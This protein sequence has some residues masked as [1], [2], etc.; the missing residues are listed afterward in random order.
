MPKKEVLQSRL[1]APIIVLLMCIQAGVYW[2]DLMGYYS[3][4][5]SLV[6]MGLAE[7]IV[8]PW[9]YGEFRMGGGG[10]RGERDATSGWE[11]RETSR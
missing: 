10:G 9:V 3:S 8:F 5:W 7:G 11:G 4:G 2:L 1:R 6:L